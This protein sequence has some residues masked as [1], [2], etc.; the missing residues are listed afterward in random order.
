MEKQLEKVINKAYKAFMICGGTFAKTWG[1]KPKVIYWIYTAVVKS[2]VTRV[3]L[4]I[5]KAELSKL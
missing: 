5:S 3:K 2:I 1:L 4:K